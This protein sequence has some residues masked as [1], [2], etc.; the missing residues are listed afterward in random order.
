MTLYTYRHKV[1]FQHCDPAGIVFY[2]RYL[3]MVNTTVET[4]FEQDL[5]MSFSYIHNKMNIAVPTVSLNIKFSAPSYL[6]DILDFHFL[7]MKISKKSFQ[8]QI[9]AFC[10]KE[11][12]FSMYSTIVCT[13]Y[14]SI[15][16]LA[17]PQSLYTKIIQTIK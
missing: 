13:T 4:W 3:E 6:G 2:P 16:S 15:Q 9:E 17:W 14:K 8:F 12:R 1:L 7:P 11:Q 5:S 10:D